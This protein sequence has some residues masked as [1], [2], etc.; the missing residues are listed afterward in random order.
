M[1]IQCPVCLTENT[2]TRQT[3]K[4]CG[5]L[6]GRLTA[7]DSPLY[8]PPGTFLKSGQYKIEQVLGEGG[9][10]KTY[11]AI[12]INNS[13]IVALKELFPDK[14]GRKGTSVQWP[15]LPKPLQQEQI[16]R[17]KLEATYLAKCNHPSIVNYREYFEENN[18]AYIVM[19]FISGKS[20]GDILEDEKT[21]AEK[22]VEQYFRQLA[23]ALEIIHQNELLHR[24]IK[25]EN[26]LID[27]QNRAVL[28]DFGAAREFIAGQTQQMTRILTPGYAPVEQY[29]YSAKRSP[30][31]DLYALC[32]SMYHLLTGQ[33]P[34]ESLERYEAISKGR[35]DPLISPRKINPKL[36][37]QMEKILLMGMQIDSQKR[38]R[39][40]S[41][42]IKALDGDLVFPILM[43][44][45]SLVRDAKV[46]G[47]QKQAKLIDAV[48][49]YEHFLDCEPSHIEAIIELAQ[50][51]T[52]S[53]IAKAEKYALMTLKERPNN[54]IIYGVL[55]LVKCYNS[56][57]QEAVSYLQQASIIS[58]KEY[59][60]QVNLA[61]ALGQNNDWAGAR[62]A[63]NKAFTLMKALELS[64]PNPDLESDY[65][66]LLG[67][68][69][70]ID[71]HQE[72]W[73][74]AIASAR[75]AITKLKQSGSQAS[76]EL[77]D[78]IYPCLI[79]SLEK[80]LR[81]KQSR[82]LEICLAEFN[83]HSFVEGYRAWQMAVQGLEPIALTTFEQASQKPKVP[84]WVW[85]NLGILHERHQNLFQAKQCYENY[86][87]KFPDAPLALLR[88]G[89]VQAL[90]DQW[91]EAVSVLEK[92]VRIK[93]DYAEAYHNLGW[94]LLNLMKQGTRVSNRV[95]LQSVYRQAVQLYEQQGKS[96]LAQS[97]R[98]SFQAIKVQL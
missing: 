84:G 41:H 88:L 4:A 18:T 2:E 46:F 37:T 45:R 48:K 14:G 50:V 83:D 36:T 63:T 80:A 81:G 97:I 25:P 29:I 73:K 34:P 82:D 92:A 47:E 51:M 64:E 98:Q 31:S 22:R 26:I 17:F 72:N 60:I 70:W 7:S 65:A 68:K 16:D 11:Q 95:E 15:L 30:S 71:F 32:A 27:G 90:L 58:P 74:E 61:W 19:D 28:I 23:E 56:S 57:W 94:V 24:D 9:F 44:A 93:P 6:L 55:G 53:D 54:G 91:E 21:L 62:D 5:S 87:Q 38:F 67:L 89:T 12:E 42:L 86:L 96:V 8:L 77:Q 20:L 10:G 3:C 35:Q 79:L 69:A 66:F 40:G 75:Q 1:S 33:V 76:Q 78:W 43:E 59:W 85:L 13:Q 52:Y 39:H 49:A